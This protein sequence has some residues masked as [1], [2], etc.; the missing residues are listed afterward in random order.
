M[1]FL[2]IILLTGF[3]SQAQN[4]PII[5]TSY[6]WSNHFTCCGGSAEFTYR[7][8]IGAPIT[9]G[10]YAY[11]TVYAALSTHPDDWYRR[12]YIREDSNRRV[13]LAEDPS[14]PGTLIYDFT[15][16]PGD[17]LQWMVC[18]SI[19]EV[20]MDQKLRKT[21][22]LHCTTP[23]LSLPETWIEGMLNLSSTFLNP[24]GKWC[25]M[26][27]SEFVTCIFK[28]DSLVFGST[29]ANHCMTLYPQ[30]IP[31]TWSATM[32][33]QWFYD[34]LEQNPF[35]SQVDNHGYINIHYMYGTTHAGHS[36]KKMVCT[37]YNHLGQI[38]R[39]VYFFTY[40][41]ND[42]VYLAF[43]YGFSVL[44]D[45]GAKPGESWTIRNPYE[46][47]GLT[48]DADSI[49]V[50]T[51]DS[52]KI[53]WIGI[54]YGRK[55][56]F[57]QSSTPWRFQTYF[58]VKTAEPGFMFP[59]LWD[60][61]NYPKPGSMRCYFDYYSYATSYP[62]YC[63]ALTTEIP[64]QESDEGITISSYSEGGNYYVSTNE[65]SGFSGNVLLIDLLG[66]ILFQADIKHV[67]KF[68]ISM[69]GKAQGIYFLHLQDDSGK[70][71]TIKLILTQ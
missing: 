22:Y 40:F 51:V 50:I 4:D 11:Y 12:A 42:K 58:L 66:R 52:V 44:Y 69:Q 19:G 59:G 62:A 25:V 49:S 65:S 47:Y 5:D 24:G 45:Y 35:S 7:L 67:Q 64:V 21:L 48:P 16:V 28:E 41:S 60:E 26:T 54:G 30:S 23:S 3:R 57:T 1:V 13:W 32:I 43:D 33:S 70:L 34:Y 2:S 18:D 17:T 10:T 61:W 15:M 31:D 46:I 36:C 37:V 6:T 71:Q 56:I 63:T 38:V 53:Q 8:R 20:F 39:N 55:M 29:S 27:Q 68:P 9:T 14:T